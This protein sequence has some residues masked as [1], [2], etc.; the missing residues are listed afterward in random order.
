MLSYKLELLSLIIVMLLIVTIVQFIKLYQYK[1]MAFKDFNSEL[2]NSHALHK[3]VRRS[4]KK[5]MSILYID[6]DNFKRINDR[7]G[8][9][10]GDQV[11]YQ[12]GNRMMTFKKS[13]QG[14]FRIGGDE[15]IFMTDYISKE[16]TVMLA[17]ALLHL[18]AKPISI[19]ND[20]DTIYVSGS[21][22]ISSGILKHNDN[23]LFKQADQA[24]YRSKKLPNNKV[25][26]FDE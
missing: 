23:L 17:E 14:F 16:D 7:F 2:P 3:F 15:F 21:I 11:V 25:L 13:R 10:V 9:F 26:Y 8:H 22:G 12:L 4:N 24:L 5:K 18:I 20:D 6:L 1:K 19:E